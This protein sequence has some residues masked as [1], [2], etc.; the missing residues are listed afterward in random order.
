MHSLE[1][2]IPILSPRSLS[3]QSGSMMGIAFA[4]GAGMGLPWAATC[5]LPASSLAFS[6]GFTKSLFRVFHNIVQKNTYEF[7]SQCNISILFLSQ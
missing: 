4:A 1:H 3:S 2:S 5:I 6:I 7:F